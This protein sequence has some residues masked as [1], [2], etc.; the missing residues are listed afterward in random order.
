MG[1]VLDDVTICELGRGDPVIANLVAS[2]D[3]HDVRMSIPVLALAVAQHGLS[4]AQI[5]AVHGM[6]LHLTH[7]EPA[8]VS[9]TSDVLHLS[10]VSIH[11]GEPEDMAA[12][13]AVAV[14]R[15]LDFPILT[16]SPKRWE[17]ARARLPWHVELIEI[18]DLG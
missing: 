10:A 18:A 9:S 8:V 12:A 14:S 7:T 16:P 11:L 4:N 13:H 2:L 1:Y 15:Y 17:A 6:F 5:E 3:A